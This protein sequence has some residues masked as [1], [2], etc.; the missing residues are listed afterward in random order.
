MVRPFF[1]APAPA[2]K[3]SFHVVGLYILLDQIAN[4]PALIAADNP[5]ISIL[6][7]GMLTFKLIALLIFCDGKA[8][9]NSGKCH[10]PSIY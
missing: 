7:S 5:V 6:C 9:S 2:R 1:I 10:N 8:P 3:V 4:R